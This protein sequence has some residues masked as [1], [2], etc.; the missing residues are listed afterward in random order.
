MYKNDLFLVTEYFKKREIRNFS[1]SGTLD[2]RLL[3]QKP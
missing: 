2:P 3:A 1:K